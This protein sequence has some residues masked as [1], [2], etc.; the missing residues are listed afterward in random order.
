[1][2]KNSFQIVRLVAQTAAQ[3]S[4]QMRTEIDLVIIRRNRQQSRKQAANYP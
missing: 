2:L 3:N 1:M 4:R